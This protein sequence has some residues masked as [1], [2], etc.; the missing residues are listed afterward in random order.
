V[1]ALLVLLL[2]ML[3]TAVALTEQ[4]SSTWA[5]Q[6]V[7]F[8]KTARIWGSSLIA[9]PVLAAVAMANPWALVAMAVVIVALNQLSRTMFRSTAASRIDGLTGLAN[10]LTLSRTL[11]DRLA[12]L[13]PGGSVTLLMIDLNRFKDVNDTYGHLVG[14]EVLVQVGRRLVAT[15]RADDLVARYGGDEFAVVLGTNAGP[16]RAAAA[17]AAIRDALAEP[18]DVRDIRVVVG[19]SVGLA[20]ATDRDTEMQVLVDQADQDMYRA[21]RLLDTDSSRPTPD[22]PPVSSAPDSDSGRAP[23][24]RPVPAWSVTVQGASAAPSAGWPGVQWSAAPPST[25]SRTDLAV[26]RGLPLDG[27]LR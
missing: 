18:V 5:E 2:G 12:R 6:R 24:P 13:A 20:R 3:L 26:R 1:I 21:K 25:D 15:A 4:R 27:G 9:A 11:S 14:D 7:R 10:R 17:A 23:R 22:V 8:G 16:A 19:G